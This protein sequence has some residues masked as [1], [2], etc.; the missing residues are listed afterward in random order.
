LTPGNLGTAPDRT[1]SAAVSDI[2]HDGD[3]DIVVSNDAPDRKLVFLNDGKGHFTEAGTF[4]NPEWTTRY[5]T[6]A[7]LD[8]DGFPDIV[9]ANRGDYPDLVECTGW[10]SRIL[11]VTAGGI[12]LLRVRMRPMRSGSA[13]EQGRADSGL[14]RLAKLWPATGGL[15][16]K[17]SCCP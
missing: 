4:G 11:T 15:R 14:Y 9:V 3:L 17:V 1:Y 13:A 10:R 5:V 12:L 8:G 2:D 16:E 7:N 6:V